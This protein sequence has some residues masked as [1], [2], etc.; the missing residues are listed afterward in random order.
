MSLNAELLG[1]STSALALSSHHPLL[2]KATS[3]Q[4]I[5]GDRLSS[6]TTGLTT[7]Y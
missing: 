7:A 1:L 5:L 2:Q 4:I 6:E 3:S